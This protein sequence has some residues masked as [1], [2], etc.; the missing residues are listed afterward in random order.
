MPEQFIID[1]KGKRKAIMLSIK[2]YEK[3]LE[4]LDDLKVMLSR[5]SEKSIPWEEAKKRL[6]KSGLL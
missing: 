4:D 2:E 1:K 5:K 3:L 6:K